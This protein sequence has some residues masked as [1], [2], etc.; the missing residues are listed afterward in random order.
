[1]RGAVAAMAAL[2]ERHLASA[3]ARRRA[4]P[5]S[6][7]AAFLPATIA[8]HYLKKLRQAGNDP[9]DPVLLR[10][11]QLQSWRLLGARLRGRF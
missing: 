3:R 2:A 8:G 10:P 1:L 5:R 9:F 11:D 6:V 4:I 7:Q